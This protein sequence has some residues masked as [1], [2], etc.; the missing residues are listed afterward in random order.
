MILRALSSI[1]SLGFTHCDIKP[2]NVLVFYAK[3]KK[4]ADFGLAT[5]TSKL[6]PRSKRFTGLV[7][8][9]SHTHI[10]ISYTLIHLYRLKN[11]KLTEW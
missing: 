8:N 6:S 9:I 5:E 7:S 11:N 3:N 2:D 1:H 10:I 4:I